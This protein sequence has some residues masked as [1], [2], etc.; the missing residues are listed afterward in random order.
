M[1]FSLAF[2]DCTAHMKW[3][4]HPLIWLSYPRRITTKTLLNILY[5]PLVGLPYRPLPP[6][7]L[8]GSGCQ[9]RTTPVAQISPAHK[10]W[11][12]QPLKFFARYV[13]RITRNPLLNILHPPLVASRPFPP[14]SLEES[15]YQTRTTPVAQRNKHCIKRLSLD[16]YQ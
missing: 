8:E 14:F 11:A 15:V 2:L 5:P 3:A 12:W 10:K 16:T 4:W 9:T 1:L 6:F 13:C 7:S